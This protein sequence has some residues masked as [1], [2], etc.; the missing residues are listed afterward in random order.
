MGLRRDRVSTRPM[1]EGGPDSGKGSSP[2]MLPTWPKTLTNATEMAR[3]SGVRPMVL[4]VQVEMSG[5]EK[6]MPPT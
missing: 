1:E 5:L 3:F 4:D 2:M 6:Y